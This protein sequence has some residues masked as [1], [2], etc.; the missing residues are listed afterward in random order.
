MLY[1]PQKCKHYCTLLF[2]DDHLGHVTQAYIYHF[3]TTSSAEFAHGVIESMHNES[4]G[5]QCMMY[6]Q[7]LV[8]YIRRSRIVGYVTGFFTY[9]KKG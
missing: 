2:N 4:L 9:I 8:N 7:L 5:M 6:R 3:L 1:R